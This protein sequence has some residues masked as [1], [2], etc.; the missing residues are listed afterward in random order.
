VLHHG[1]AQE[2]AS[3][4]F[5]TAVTRL[6]GCR[7][8]I[9]LAPMGGNSGAAL[10]TAVSRAGGFGFIGGGYADAGWV[11]KQLE[12]ADLATVGIGFITWHLKDREAVLQEA[13]Q[14]KP[15]AV[16]LSFGDP[17]PYLPAIRQAGSLLVLQVQSVAEAKQAARWGADLIVAQGTEA[18]GHGA[19]RATL[20]LV[21]AVVDAVSPVPVAA[22]G[23]IG[24][25]RGIAAALVLG[26]EGVLVGTRFMVAHESL[27]SDRAKARLV[28]ASG[29]DTVR[30]RVF[31]IVRG[32]DWPAPYTGR[33]LR[34][35]FSD[36]WHGRE[37]E[38]ERE[39]SRERPL[40]QQAVAEQ[41]HGTALVFAGE[42]VDLIR[43][44]DSASDIVADLVRETEAALRHA[45][46]LAGA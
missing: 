13:L 30:T 22:A 27:T 20:P 36:Q 18:G 19:A 17:T 5:D 8:P 9:L 45:G 40:Y 21:P 26:A 14:R 10:A 44:K 41:D 4:N 33:A 15:K 23:G 39:L 25:G 24:D 31:D 12:Q 7:Y 42:G 1:S 34:N 35:R 43:R 38:L 3:M 11:R 6:L 2:N 37:Q 46:T 16:F 32:Y 29:E 28:E